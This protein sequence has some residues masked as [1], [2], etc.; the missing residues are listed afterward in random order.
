[1]YEKFRL[2]VH[3]HNHRINNYVCVCVNISDLNYYTAIIV[4][5]EYFLISLFL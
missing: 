2:L 4:D 3:I 1:M 5:I